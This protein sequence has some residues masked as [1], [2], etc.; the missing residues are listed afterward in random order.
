MPAKASRIRTITPSQAR[1][2]WLHAQ[3]LDEAAPF[4][5]GPEATRLA[6][7]HLG[8]VQI[9][10]I[11]VIERSHHHILFSRVPGYRRGDLR[12]AQSMDKSVFEYWTH[13]LSYVPTRDL[14]FFL[15]E[16]KRH[17]TE[18]SRWYA[19][20]NPNDLKRML[21]N[22]RKDG[23]LSIR[24][25]DDDELVE[26]DHP[27]AS[28]KP[29]KRVLQL[30]FY[31]GDLTIS[32]RN[33]M[34]K[35]YELMERHFGWNQRPKAAT[36]KQ[37]AEY[38]LDR[39]LRSQG[40]VSL[41][42][43]SYL[44]AKRK[45]VFKEL[46]E[47][48]VRCKQLVPVTIEGVEKPQFWATPEV[49]DAV[50][51]PGQELVHILSPFD[52]LIIQRKRTSAIF[53]YDHL[54]EAYVPKAKRKYGYFSLPVLVGEEIVA[55]LDLKTDRAARKVLI[56]NWTWMRPDES[57]RLKGIVEEALGRFEAF[58]LGD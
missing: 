48:R 36:D 21:R 29:S 41:E 42:S 9:D 1:R 25:I 2:I 32:E 24:D 27:W 14:R 15:P 46:I 7:E 11:N 38:L 45:P 35:T 47:G 4:G 23:A 56:Q 18:P 22:I 39:A 10:T 30:G 5:E 6:V 52:P 50:P 16:M 51:E 54:F 58:Q 3:R 37:V 57:G 33:G 53:G 13:A 31:N 40:L 49:L 55:A 28:R 26:K 20:A 17:K 19:D 43:I 44:E 12:Q 34:V 8:Y